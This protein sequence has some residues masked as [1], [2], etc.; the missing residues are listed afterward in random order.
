MFVCQYFLHK[1]VS[2][3]SLKCIEFESSQNLDTV[4]TV[5]R[6]FCN[7]EG[8]STKFHA[9][10]RISVVLQDLTGR[11]PRWKY[12]NADSSDQWGISAVIMD[13]SSKA[14]SGRLLIWPD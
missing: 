2:F 3:F 10:D 7:W 4:V 1:K 12:L 6:I 8:Q 5:A 14:S 9:F 11:P 13:M